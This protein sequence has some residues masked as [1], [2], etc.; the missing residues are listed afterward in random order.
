[1]T[2]QEQQEAGQTV[3][4]AAAPSWKDALKVREDLV[5]RDMYAFEMAL[6]E[7]GGIVG[8]GSSIAAERA[9]KAAID[10]G[11]L[12]APASEVVKR[13]NGDKRHELDG[14][15]VDDTHPGIVRWYG[16]AILQQYALAVKPPPN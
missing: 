3:D 13:A 14:K 8:F 11:W 4:K 10:A 15:P 6:H 1:M 5:Q 9:L 7:L 16:S 12:E 2:E